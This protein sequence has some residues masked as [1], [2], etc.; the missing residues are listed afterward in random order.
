[1]DLS[2]TGKGRT[3]PSWDHRSAG[4]YASLAMAKQL[5][6]QFA[7]FFFGWLD[8][9]ADNATG[10]AC[11]DDIPYGGEP[12]VH[13]MTCYAHISWQYHLSQRLLRIALVRSSESL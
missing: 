4:I 9:N 2:T 10:Y 1:M 8:A 12:Q 11:A 13:W 7:D 5:S 6:P 3:C